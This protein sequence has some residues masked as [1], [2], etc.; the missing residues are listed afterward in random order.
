MRQRNKKE[1]NPLKRLIIVLIIL[2]LTAFILMKSQ[3]Y[4]KEKSEGEINLI[5]N[6]NNVTERLKH[7]V[8]IKDGIIYVSMDDI[9][10]FFDKYIYIEDEINEVVTTYDK[11]IASIGFEVKKLTLNGAMKKI[12]ASAIKENDEVYLPISE[13]TDVYNMEL[14]H[15]EKKRIITIDSLNKEQIKAYTK[16]KVS[17][18]WKKEFLSKTVDKVEKG[19]IVIAISQ[20]EDGWTKVRTENG[21]I[22][23]VK[24]KKLT[25]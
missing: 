23:Y 11:K 25:N 12:N 4:L 24:T 15:I 6:N 5:I 14:K 1:N 8:K 2:V 21:K 19:G 18:K 20:N 9:K 22:G 16:S 3:N 17:V 13:M 7:E 10:N